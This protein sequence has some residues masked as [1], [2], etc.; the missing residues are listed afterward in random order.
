MYYLGAGSL[1]MS[2]MANES[3]AKHI[4]GFVDNNVTK[5]GKKIMG[6]EIHS[7]EI[8]KENKFKDHLV[9]IVCMRYSNSIL[10]QIHEMEI[11]NEVIVY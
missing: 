7:P 5:I 8:L 11:Q 2:L 6:K 9:L 3:L 4:G 10:K 1:A